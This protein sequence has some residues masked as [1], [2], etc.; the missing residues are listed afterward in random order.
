MLFILRWRLNVLPLSE[1]EARAT[2]TRLGLL[3]AVTALCATMI[4]AASVAMCGQVAWIGL[5][6][7]HICRMLFGSD[8]ARL[9]PASLSIGAVFLLLVDTLARSVTASEIPISIL[10]ACIGAPFFIHLLR[11]TRG[12]ES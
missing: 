9:M 11:Q 8:S 3:R 5:L 12:W 2:G 10:T 7:P 4:T 6:V 1:D